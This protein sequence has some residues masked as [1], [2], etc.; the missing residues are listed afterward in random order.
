MKVKTELVKNYV[1][2]RI[3]DCMDDVIEFDANEIIN[4][5]AIEILQENIFNVLTRNLQNKFP[6]LHCNEKR[7][8]KTE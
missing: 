4:T 3:C 8:L 2:S 6:T 7:G 5:K 1:T